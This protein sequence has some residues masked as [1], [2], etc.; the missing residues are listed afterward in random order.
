VTLFDDTLSPSV[1]PSLDSTLGA[2]LESMERMQR[3]VLYARVSSDAQQKEGT[4]ESQVVELKRQIAAAGHVLVKE[5]LDD[6]I[7]GAVLDRPALEQLRRDAKTNLFDRIYFHAAD[8]ITREAAHQTII[9]GELLNRGKQLTIGGKDYQQ[10]PENK[11]TLQMLGVFSEYERA[12]IIERTTRGRLHRLGTGEMSSNGHRIYGYKYVKKT[13]S[14]PATLVI[15][16]EQAA[17]VRSIFEMFA[18]G[19]FGLVTISRFLEERRVPTRTGRPQWDRG[20]IKFMLKN[21][22]YTGTR[23]FNRITAVTDENRAGKQVIRGKWVLRDR[24]EWIAVKVPAIVSRELFD[25]VQEK[26][27]LHEERYCQ[28]VT[29]YLLS[30]LVQCGVCGSRCSS[31]RGYHKV[32]RPSG[33]VSV[34]HQA[35]YRCNRRAQENMH[36][37]TRIERCRN[38]QISTHILEGKVFEMIRE[39]MLDT[40]TLRRCTDSGAELDDQSIARELAR[41]AGHIKGLDG[42][43]RRIIG[44]YAAEQMA[45]EEYIAANRVLDRDLE[46]LARRKAELVAAL[47]SPQHEDFVDASIR[48]FCASANARLQAC[49]DFD[50]K[51]QFVMDHVERVIYTGYKVAITGFVPV[52]SASGASKLQFRIKGEIDKAAVRSNA[53][54]RNRA[55]K[56]ML[57]HPSVPSDTSLP[58][59]SKL[60]HENI[61]AYCQAEP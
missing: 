3:A 22:T 49:A 17:I 52:Q 39:V 48:Q 28:P 58:V 50:A 11:L 23:Y 12:K 47:R 36:D 32:R 10:N 33:K 55:S 44:L 61:A 7:T 24:S 42:E 46:R 1:I 54:S 21:E 16:E 56:S 35:V 26:L 14:A 6:G 13:A 29:H 15:N 19:D 60:P 8:R 4:I 20:Q 51:R 43:R 38:S 30:G 9:I 41:I 2:A 34:Y 27:R 45:G 18:S 37:R 40:A 31:S 53:Q 59:I 25:K 5:Y 57:L